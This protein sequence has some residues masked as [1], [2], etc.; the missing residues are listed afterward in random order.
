VIHCAGQYGLPPYGCGQ[1]S[2]GQPELR[3]VW[4]KSRCAPRIWNWNTG[5]VTTRPLIDPASLIYDRSKNISLQITKNSK[6]RAFW[7]V[8]PCSLVGADRRFRGAYCLY[9]QGDDWCS[10]HHPDDGG[11]THLSNVGVLQWDYKALHPRRLW[12]S[13]SPP[14]ERQISQQRIR[15]TLICGVLLCKKM[16]RE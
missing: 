8:A 5:H 16:W 1:V 2:Y 12:S 9:H 11:S 13:H 10:T 4:H 7:D 3:V 6:I 15:W 14:W